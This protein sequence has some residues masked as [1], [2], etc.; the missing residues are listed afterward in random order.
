MA[1]AT[2]T[3]STVARGLP[4]G[5]T[6]TNRCH[7]HAACHCHMHTC[8]LSLSD[9]HSCCLIA[10]A[11]ARISIK[12]DRARSAV[13]QHM[14][15]APPAAAA[16]R[17]ARIARAAAWRL[18]AASAARPTMVLVADA[19]PHNHNN[20]GPRPQCT[21]VCA[22]ARRPPPGP[23]TPMPASNDPDVPPHLCCPITCDIFQDPVCAC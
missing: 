1:V 13:S 5:R 23:T 2:Y 4:Y 22:S 12:S 20:R 16:A 3:Y 19:G 11:C 18:A 14:H 8:C 15:I 17:G 9:K 10:S 6:E 21:P 7:M